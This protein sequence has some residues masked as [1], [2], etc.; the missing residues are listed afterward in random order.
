MGCRVYTNDGPLLRAGHFAASAADAL[1]HIEV[2]AVLFSG[3]RRSG[4]DEPR[5]VTIAAGRRALP[6]VEVGVTFFCPVEQ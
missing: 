4:G 1:A 3:L 6:K 5:S 2:E